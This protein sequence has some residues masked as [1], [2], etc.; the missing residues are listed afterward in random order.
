MTYNVSS[1]TLNPTTPYHTVSMCTLH[2]QMQNHPEPPN[3]RCPF[4]YIL[5]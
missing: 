3:V 2:S 4:V 1:G 5:A